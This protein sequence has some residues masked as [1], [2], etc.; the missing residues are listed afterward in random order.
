MM[1]MLPPKSL[2]RFIFST[3]LMFIGLT[4]SGQPI[5]LVEPDLQFAGL[6]AGQ[7]QP[8]TFQLTNGTD[9]AI[10]IQSADAACEC[11]TLKQSPAEI[12][13]H[14]V[15]EFVWI[16]DSTRATGPVSQ[17]VTVEIAGGPTIQG[18]FS[19]SV[20]ARNSASGIAGSLRPRGVYIHDPSTIAGCGHEHWFFSTGMGIPSHHSTTFTNWLS[21]PRVFRQMPA[22]I[23]QAVPGN[24]GV[25]WAPDI[26]R[27]NGE[28]FLY[29]AASTWGQRVSA[30]GLATNPTLDPA[31]PNFHWTDAG[32]VLCTTLKDD[33]NAIDPG[34]FRDDDGSLWLAFGSYW[35]GIKLIQLNPATGLRIAADSPVYSLARR[36]AGNDTSIEAACL[37]RHG[38]FYYLLVNWYACCRGTNSTYEIR[39]GR[40]EKVSGPYV[41]STGRDMLANGGDVFLHSQ[42]RFIGPG[43]A[44]IYQENGANWFS[45]HFYDGDNHG[46]AS[47]G[48]RP[49]V[50]AT[51]GWP[52]LAGAQP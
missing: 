29:Y 10:K 49:L 35:S 51:N 45:F 44:G 43:H 8:V 30:I 28:Y 4:A 5:R 23:T 2:C 1:P 18:Q 19:T 46:L 16:Y 13:A 40:S 22:W 37:T 14:G 50:W 39:M 48:V 34:V 41:D 12:P 11:T 9:A 17:T 42:G 26:I 20:S 7:T 33:F 38:Q 25:L 27:Q 21:G 32:L 31:A 24:Q 52:A 36:K 6:T 47:I 3:L 15:G